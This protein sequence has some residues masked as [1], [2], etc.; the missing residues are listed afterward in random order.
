[1]ADSPRSR[2]GS[3]SRLTPEEIT[4]RG[5]ASAFRGISE[6][7]VRN[8]LKRVADEI[9]ALGAREAELQRRVDDLQEQVAH[10]PAVTEEQLL[11]SL[12]EE[13]ARV[14]RSAQEAAEEIR[15]RAEERAATL[16]REAQ[17]ESTRL[18]ES[19]QQYEVTRKEAADQKA[20]E[21]E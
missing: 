19:A 20:S 16:V 17:E 8:F 9:T 12:G 2:G 5:F 11:S 7:E 14:L 6:T 3:P 21:L 15:K 10:P 4:N 13:T 18:R 1:M